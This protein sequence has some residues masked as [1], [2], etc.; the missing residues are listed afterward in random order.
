MSDSFSPN[1]L[2]T[3]HPNRFSR[4]RLR[5]IRWIRDMTNNLDTLDVNANSADSDPIVSTPEAQPVINS[6]NDNTINRIRDRYN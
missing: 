6:A 3:I 2:L 4:S 5:N 1:A